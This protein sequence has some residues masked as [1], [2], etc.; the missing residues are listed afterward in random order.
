LIEFDKLISCRVLLCKNKLFRF[1]SISC[2]SLF[3]WL[4]R[5]FWLWFL[6]SWINCSFWN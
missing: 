5:F 2:F 1:A 3:C 4:W 6:L